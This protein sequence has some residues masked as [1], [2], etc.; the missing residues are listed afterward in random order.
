[1]ACRGDHH[2]LH[3][4]EARLPHRA[5]D[6]RDRIIPERHGLRRRQP[7]HQPENPVIVPGCSLWHSRLRSLTRQKPFSTSYDR[8]SF[9][10][11]VLTKKRRAFKPKTGGLPTTGQKRS[12]LTC[13]LIRLQPSE[14][15]SPAYHSPTAPL[16]V[17][18]ASERPIRGQVERR[19]AGTPCQPGGRFIS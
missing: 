4:I 9:R 13:L 17:S 15:R 8:L 18:S 7:A 5:L 10:Q 19:F 3:G 11:P 12:L 1:M 2:E 14:D 6:L 16:S